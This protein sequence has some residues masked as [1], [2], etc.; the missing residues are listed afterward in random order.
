MDLGSSWATELPPS[1]SSTW[2]IHF[3]WA[4]VCRYRL[5]A[6]LVFSLHCVTP[7]CKLQSSYTLVTSLPCS[8]QHFAGVSRECD[9]VS[10]GARNK[11]LSH[12]NI[13]RS[14]REG[15]LSSV[16]S[17]QFHSPLPDLTYISRWYMRPHMLHSSA[18][19]VFVTEHL[20]YSCYELWIWVKAALFC[21]VQE[22]SRGSV[23][24]YAVEHPQGWEG[25]GRGLLKAPF[26]HLPG[27][28]PMQNLRQGIRGSNRGPHTSQERHLC[29][30]LFALL[31]SDVV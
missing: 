31:W 21:D 12:V 9:L 2:D 18:P 19:N 4:P 30:K 23:R 11:C 20:Q 24:S 17:S 29:S 10:D 26:L 28:K 8:S 22:V 14:A 27:R 6:S 15:S 13:N 3:A 25:S 1:F 5:H 7:A 16:F